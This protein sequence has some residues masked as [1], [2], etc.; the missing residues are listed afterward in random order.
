MGFNS[1]Q[2]DSQCGLAKWS[3][4]VGRQ[5]QIALWNLE[6]KGDEGAGD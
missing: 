1:R 2:L 4:L 3:L 5:C 6:G